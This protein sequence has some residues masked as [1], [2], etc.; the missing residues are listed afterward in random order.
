MTLTTDA[1]TLVA[2][3]RSETTPDDALAAGSAELEGDR[4][5]FDRFVDAFAPAPGQRAQSPAPAPA[6]SA[7]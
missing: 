4:I 7:S 5:A 6:Q 2:L 3:R 1:R